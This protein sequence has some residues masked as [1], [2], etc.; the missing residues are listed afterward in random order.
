MRKKTFVKNWLALMLAVLS[1]T[2]TSRMNLAAA[3]TATTVKGVDVSISVESRE[4]PYELG[5]K[6]PVTL[7]QRILFSVPTRKGKDPRYNC[8]PSR[9][10]FWLSFLQ[11][12]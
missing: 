4:N 12:Q 11:V 5:K 2:C 9:S 1:L 7:Y 6:V 8:H 10:L 3:E